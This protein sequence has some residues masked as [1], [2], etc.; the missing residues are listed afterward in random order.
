MV[1]VAVRCGFRTRADIRNFPDPTP[2]HPL[3]MTRARRNSHL[4]TVTL[5][6][7]TSRRQRHPRDAPQVPSPSTEEDGEEERTDEEAE[8]DDEAVGD[9]SVEIESPTRSRNGKAAPLRR[10]RSQARH[11]TLLGT[12]SLEM[13]LEDMDL[14]ED[15]DDVVI[16]A[17]DDDVEMA[18]QVSDAQRELS[19]DAPDVSFVGETEDEDGGDE[20]GEDGWS[21][22]VLP[23]PLER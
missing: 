18:D 10:L 22:T 5:Q 3:P 23:A 7:P 16:T 19:S 9:E 17:S 2:K 11:D 21:W 20:A 15:I 12:G 14:E 4:A 6:T 1:C 13:R 8:D